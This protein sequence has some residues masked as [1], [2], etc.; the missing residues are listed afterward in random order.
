MTLYNVL[1]VIPGNQLVTIS[2]YLTGDIYVDR[3]EVYNVIEKN[4]QQWHRYHGVGIKSFR[5]Y[6]IEIGT[7][8]GDLMVS[9]LE[10]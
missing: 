6:K 8:Y 5:V 4:D 3:K 10:D 9:I 2:D 7:V 1:S